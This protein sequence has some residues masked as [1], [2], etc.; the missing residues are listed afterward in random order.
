MSQVSKQDWTNPIAMAT[1]RVDSLLDALIG[2]AA[3]SCA[4]AGETPVVW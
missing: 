1:L 3:M 4:V 2:P